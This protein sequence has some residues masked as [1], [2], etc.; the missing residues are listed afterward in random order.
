[1]SIVRPYPL[2]ALRPDEFLVEPVDPAM[3]GMPVHAVETSEPFDLFSYR[4]RN[5]VH[6]GRTAVQDV[7][8]C[9]TYN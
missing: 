2:P 7:V 8:I 5:M 6:A 3:L 9:D 1:M 4:V